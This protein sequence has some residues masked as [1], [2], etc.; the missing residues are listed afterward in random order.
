MNK[1]ALKGFVFGVIF[2]VT[3]MAIPFISGIYTIERD[4]S[5]RIGQNDVDLLPFNK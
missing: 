3:I 1:S 2:T 4:Y 5:S